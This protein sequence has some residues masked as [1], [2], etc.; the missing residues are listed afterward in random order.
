MADLNLAERIIVG[1]VR[2]STCPVTV[3]M[4]SGP[5]QLTQNG[6]TLARIAE[7][8]GVSALTV[9]GRTWKQAFGGMADWK[10]I[11]RIKSSV[12]I[13]VIGNGDIV[14]FQDAEQ[15]LEKSQC[16]GVMIGQP[17]SATPGYSS[18][19]AGR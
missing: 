6:L 7:D 2:S 3:K 11:E 19:P 12:S 14:T 9:H 18:R 15:R 13:P 17:H 16:D 8:N 10:V 5:D 4:R 1:V